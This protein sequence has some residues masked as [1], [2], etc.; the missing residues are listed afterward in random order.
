LH[1]TVLAGDQ[2]QLDMPRTSIW[3]V[4]LVLDDGFWPD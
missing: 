4:D 1:A 3:P 2:T